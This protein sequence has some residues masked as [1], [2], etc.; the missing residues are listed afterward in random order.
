[1]NTSRSNLA[2]GKR[3]A[4]LS[5][6]S[7]QSRETFA[8]F[9]LAMY[10]AQCVE[11]QLSIL[12]ATTLQP[13]FLRLTPE[14][15]DVYFDIEFRKTLGQL[16]KSLHAGIPVPQALEGRLSRALTLRNWLAHEYF[17]QRSAQALSSRGRDQMIVELREAAEFLF[18][19]D[20][21]LTGISEAWLAQN[22]VPRGV[23]E[24]EMEAFLRESGAE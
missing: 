17:W 10:R 1:M 7:E 22:G 16:V 2:V 21:E 23:I 9:G 11:K 8:H 15:R 3:Q 19:V 5:A 4:P 12:L 13:A 14:E 6:D 20:T 24:A 18:S